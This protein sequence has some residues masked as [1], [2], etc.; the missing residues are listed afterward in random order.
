MARKKS[1][2]AGG[3]LG[4]RILDAASG[5]FYEQ[6]FGATSI[7]QIAD[8]VGI[9]SSTLYHYFPD[10]QGVLD[11]VLT[12][13]AGDFIALL[14][15]ILQDPGA[16]P[17]DRVA[18]AVEAHIA[19]S[20]ERG[21][22]L[23]LGSPIHHALSKVQNERWVS[24]QREYHHAMRATVAEGIA[25][26]DFDLADATIGT[27]AVMDMLNGVRAWFRPDGALGLPTVTAYYVEMVLRTLGARP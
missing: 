6:G 18:R 12:R 16:A 11:A 3:P 2:D 5:L 1:L 20:A 25:S 9:S 14:A 27:L 23:L 19:I 17:A 10:K 7:R 4:A 8:A 13:F 26:G 22:E 21:P 24:A 15:P